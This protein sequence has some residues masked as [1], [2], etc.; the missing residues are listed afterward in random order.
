V[1]EIGSLAAALGGLEALVFTGGI[2]EHDALTRRQI[3]EGCAWLGLSLDAPRNAAGDGRISSD[4]SRLA[5]WVVPT[6]EEKMIARHTSA[7]LGL[8]EPA[9]KAEAHPVLP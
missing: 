7:L 1:R 4:A 8:S 5:A 3:A 6:D 9:P 2:G